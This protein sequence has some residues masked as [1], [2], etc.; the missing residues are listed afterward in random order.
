MLKG[1]ITM[2]QRQQKNHDEFTAIFPSDTIWKWQNMVE[3][4]NANRKAPNPYVEPVASKSLLY[5]FYY[6]IAHF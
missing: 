6:Y 1:A 4:W 5:D 2:S 3:D